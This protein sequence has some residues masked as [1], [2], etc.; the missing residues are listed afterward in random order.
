MNREV[1]IYTWQNRQGKAH[2]YSP[3]FW[4]FQIVG[5]LAF[6][7]VTFPLKLNITGGIAGALLLCV[8][9]DGSSFLLTLGLRSIYRRFWSDQIGPMAAVIAAAC[10]VGGIAQ[11]GLFLAFYPLLPFQGEILFTRSME[12]NLLYERIGLLF[13]W[14]FLYFA[15]RLIIT[16]EQRE[17]L[18]VRVESEYRAAELRLLR[19]IMNPHFLFNAL[20]FIRAELLGKCEPLAQVV[21]AF[22]NYLQY[23]LI[24]RNETFVA[25]GQE[26]DAIEGYLAVEKAR[27][28]SEVEI[29]CRIDAEVRQVQ[30]PGIIIQPLVEN[31]F[32]YGR[33]Q[34]DNLPL[35]IGVYV[36]R[37]GNELH[38]VVSNSGVWQ[39]S[40]QSKASS[41]IGLE[42]LKE[43][44]W[45]LYGDRHYFEILTDN[46]QVVVKV[47]IP[48]S[49]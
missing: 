8:T 6:I 31:A 15:I 21:Q 5:W 16:G 40:S 3:L 37:I 43:R 46:N 28:G 26:F 45:L 32:K 4:R 25:A 20:N 14:S 47:H 44:L 27:F 17:T 34:P 30:V 7:V 11:A 49:N 35:K 19:S 38:L 24:T 9:R 41:G 48:V 12:F 23:S 39:P 10:M 36:T 22:T 42:S 33:R 29:E 18:L 2:Q 1:S 13:S